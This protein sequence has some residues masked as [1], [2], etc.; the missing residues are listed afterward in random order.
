MIQLSIKWV[1]NNCGSN[2]LANKNGLLKCSI[3]G[4]KRDSE[5]LIET[6]A[7]NVPLPI[8]YWEP[9]FPEDNIK[10]NLEI[11]RR[12]Y[13][14]IFRS[15]IPGN[16]ILY[17]KNENHRQI[18]KS[19]LLMTKLA[20]MNTEKFKNYDFNLE[21]QVKESYPDQLWSIDTQKYRLDYKKLEE[22]G[23]NFLGAINVSGIY[24]YLI[25]NNKTGDNHFYT[26]WM[27][28]KLGILTE[29]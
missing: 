10:W 21:K 26:N 8:D 1:C 23:L 6:E 29:L 17:D 14:S 9:P 20:N 7:E 18:S 25:G 16:Y 3:C 4:K 28:K 13:S 12:M 27:C 5:E 19:Q 22:L 15:D 2:N 24:G 11:L